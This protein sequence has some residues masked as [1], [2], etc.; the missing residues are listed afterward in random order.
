MWMQ[1]YSMLLQ[2]TAWTQAHIY[3]YSKIRFDYLF[4]TIHRAQSNWELIIIESGAHLSD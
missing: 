4:Y 3:S 1:T 2:K